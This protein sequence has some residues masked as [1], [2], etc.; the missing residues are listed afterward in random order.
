MHDGDKRLRRKVKKGIKPP[1]SF[2]NSR[3]LEK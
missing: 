1:A 2:E 3:V